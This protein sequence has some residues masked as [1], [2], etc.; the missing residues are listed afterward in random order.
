APASAEAGPVSERHLWSGPALT[1]TKGK[2]V[3]TTE[4]RT[5]HE[6]LTEAV[7]P[8]LKDWGLE[9]QTDALVQVLAA[10][11]REGYSIDAFHE[12][13]VTADLDDE[14]SDWVDPYD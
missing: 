10:F 8:V 11:I 13:L 6:A 5:M 7:R 14:I 12:V 4:A 1:K 2:Q 3:T 9:E